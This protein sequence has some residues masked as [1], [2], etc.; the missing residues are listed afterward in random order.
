[1]SNR[2]NNATQH[3]RPARARRRYFSIEHANRSLVLLTR[4]VADIVDD[5][6]RLGEYQE[7]LEAGGSDDDVRRRTEGL[8]THSVTRIRCC[9]Q[10]LDDLGVEIT[11]WSRGAVDFPSLA[12]GREIRLCWALGEGRVRFWHEVNEDP[13]AHRPIDTI[14]IA[15]AAPAEL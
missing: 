10:E 15:D 5:Y 6:Q 3:V 7:T 9:L 13:S 8:L 12:A 4:V 14:P 11:D 2:L 1:M